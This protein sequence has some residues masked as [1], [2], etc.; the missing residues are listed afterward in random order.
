MFRIYYPALIFTVPLS[1]HSLPATDGSEVGRFVKSI[2]APE[3][4]KLPWNAAAVPVN[5]NA[6][7]LPDAIVKS[8]EPFLINCPKV[9]AVPS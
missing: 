7:E 8:F 9:P 2:C 3:A 1:F 5:I 6:C 4:D